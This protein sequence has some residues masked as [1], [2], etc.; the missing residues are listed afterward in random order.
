MTLQP[1]VHPVR[2]EAFSF[3]TGA[4]GLVAWQAAERASGR[5]ATFLLSCRHRRR[6]G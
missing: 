4:F 2:A 3:E 1:W 5:S 6:L